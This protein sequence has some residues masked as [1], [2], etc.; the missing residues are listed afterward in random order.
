[1][2]KALFKNIKGL[3]REILVCD[4]QPYELPTLRYLIEHTENLQ[5]GSKLSLSKWSD[6]ND[7]IV[8]RFDSKIEIKPIGL[9]K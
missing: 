5:I 3:N 1:M 8:T 7:Y 4:I 2:L 9:N 6:S